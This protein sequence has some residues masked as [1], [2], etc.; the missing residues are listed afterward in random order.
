MQENENDILKRVRKIEIKTRG[1]SDEIFAGKYHT[2]FR[3]RGMSFS[4]VR[5]YRAGDDVRDID[6]NVTARSRKPHIK[7]Y[8]EERELTMMLLVDVSASRLFGTTGRLKKNV[9]TEIAAVLAFSAAQNN[10]KVG[11]IFFSDR[12]EKFIPPK[13][14]R[15]HILAIIRELVDFRPESQGTRLSEPLRL[16]TNV[17]KKRC[18]TFILSDF[19]DPAPDRTALED[20]LKIAGSK[21]D[22]VGIR[23]FDPREQELPDVGIVEFQD[24]EKGGKI[25]L[26]TSSRAVRDHYARTWNRRSEEIESLLRHHRIDTAT[27]STAGDYVAELIKLF[28]Q[29]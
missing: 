2:A 8:E 10:D 21:H 9:I 5:E 4:E 7:V 19:L 14:G 15:S 28:R 17:N 20:A 16:L 12:V 6:W 23:V 3:G 1:L 11:C 25:W 13:K 27:V 22:L 18:T 24:A 26:D 29:R